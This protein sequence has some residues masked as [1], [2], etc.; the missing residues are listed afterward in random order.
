MI[1]LLQKLVAFKYSC[2]ISHWRTGDYAM[3]LLYDRLQE[4]MDDIIDDLAE[5]HFMAGNLKDKLTPQLLNPEM[6]DSDLAKGIEDILDHIEKGMEKKKLSEGMTS[7]LSGIAEKF[8]A[9]QAL[10]GLK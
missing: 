6:I 3:H 8:L 5:R 2:K 1:E 4:D 9:K 10:I 7:L